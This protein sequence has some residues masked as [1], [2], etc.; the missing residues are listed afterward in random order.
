M[1]TSRKRIRMPPSRPRYRNSAEEQTEKTEEEKRADERL[2]AVVVC[3]QAI[4]S[5][6]C[7]GP[8]CRDHAGHVAAITDTV[9]MLVRDSTLAAWG[10]AGTKSRLGYGYRGPVTRKKAAG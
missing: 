7:E 8:G 9:L 4:T 10:K 2:A 5:L 1:S 6:G 3:D